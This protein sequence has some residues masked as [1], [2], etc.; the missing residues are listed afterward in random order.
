MNYTVIGGRGFIGSK[1][2]EL[3][4][5][6]KET[7]WVPERDDPEL[8]T[9][10]L[11]TVIYCAGHG[12]C[13]KGYL[14]VL[15][16]NTILLSRILDGGTFEK[17]V[18][19]SSTRVYMGQNSSSESDDLI[20]LTQDSRR[21]FNLTKLVAEEILLKSE[22]DIA[23]VRPSNVYGLALNSPLFLASIVRN[24]INNG[25]VDMYVSPEY[26]KDYVSVDDVATL[27][28]K[29]SK[30][31]NVSGQI[32]NVAA[33]KNVSAKQIAQILQSKTQCKVCWHANSQ[34]EMFPITN[35]AK[36]KEKFNYK[37]SSVL[38]DLVDLINNYQHALTSND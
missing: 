30:D 6:Q 4:E 25:V 11:G 12:N 24:A 1:I 2:V 3:L 17:L 31:Q 37:P 18:Y 14:K 7:V 27:T 29:I 26:S 10:E 16:A 9:K 23:I 38:D 20:A 36:I 22:K 13:D 35:I 15:E 8:F 28:I 33:G 19:I 32:F 21:L 5:K 34:D